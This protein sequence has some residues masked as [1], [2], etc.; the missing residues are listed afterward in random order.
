MHYI[1]S[2]VINNKTT[3]NKGKGGCEVVRR[4]MGEGH[5]EKMGRVVNC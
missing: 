2:R 5:Q 1:Q 3:V 4:E